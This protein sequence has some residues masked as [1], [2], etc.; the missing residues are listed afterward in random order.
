M[1][2][3]LHSY[4]YPKAEAPLMRMLDVQDLDT[5]VARKKRRSVNKTNVRPIGNASIEVLQKRRAEKPEQRKA[6]REAALR[7]VKQQQTMYKTPVCNVGYFRP[8]C[9][10]MHVI[11]ETCPAALRVCSLTEPCLPFIRLHVALA[12]HGLVCIWPCFHV[13]LVLQVMTVVA[14]NSVA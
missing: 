4:G 9:H 1:A 3:I 13:A 11:Q 5:V 14:C 6:S 10:C 8:R 12:P 7:Y 2:V